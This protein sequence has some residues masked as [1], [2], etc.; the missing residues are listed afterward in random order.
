M[1]LQVMK[2]NNMTAANVLANF[3]NQASPR[4]QTRNPNPKPQNWLDLSTCSRFRRRT[5]HDLRLGPESLILFALAVD[6][7]VA[8]RTIYAF[9]GPE[10]LILFALAVDVVIARHTTW[11]ER[12][13]ERGDPG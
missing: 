2:V 12:Q 1:R 5:P 10:S 4:S 11:Q 9:N 7:V 3:F 13:G 8:R 6:F